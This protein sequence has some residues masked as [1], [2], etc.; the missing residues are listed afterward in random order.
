MLERGRERPAWRSVSHRGSGPQRS[1]GLRYRWWPSLHVA[2]FDRC[3]PSCAVRPAPVTDLVVSGGT[4]VTAAG[5]SRVDVAVD[6]GRITA[7]GEDGGRGAREGTSAPRGGGGPRRGAP[8]PVRARA[9]RPAPPGGR[10]GARVGR[11]GAPPTALADR[12]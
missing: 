12:G 10:G 5:S 8:R 4:V 6:D 2:R 3:P 11:G 9:P 1:L 7:V